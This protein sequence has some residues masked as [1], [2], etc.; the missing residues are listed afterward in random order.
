MQQLCHVLPPS[1]MGESH[2]ITSSQG[3]V[4]DA[5]LPVDKASIC[6]PALGVLECHASCMRWH[7][8]HSLQQL[9]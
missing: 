1:C 9:C 6:S 7:H 2:C 3:K 8:L 5:Q 4:E